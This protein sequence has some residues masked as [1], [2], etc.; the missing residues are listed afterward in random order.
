[1]AFSLHQAV[2]DQDIGKV[3]ELI[4]SGFDVN[5][6]DS[7]RRTPLH[8]AAWLGNLEIAKVLILAKANVSVKAMDLFTPLHF[9]VQ[10]ENAPDLIK[11]LVKKD[12]SLLNAR[13]SKGNKTALHL[14][15]T[16]GYLEN[17]KALVEIGADISLKTNQGQ[18]AVDV[19]KDEGIVNFLRNLPSTTKKSKDGSSSST[20]SESANGAPQDMESV[21][22][23]AAE[24][25]RLVAG[26][27]AT[28]AAAGMEV[29]PLPPP[30]PLAASADTLVQD[31]L[32]VPKRARFVPATISYDD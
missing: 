28:D 15:A 6:A 9:A 8:L 2:R 27:A 29:S 24:E 1:M 17:V 7:S 14:A 31:A 22:S 10:R 16:K 13:I 3:K 18:L 32:P 21:A 11:L 23:A 26:D 4:T 30:P 20:S 12:K 5:Q 19:A 25:G